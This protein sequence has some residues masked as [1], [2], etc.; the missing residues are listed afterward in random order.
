VGLL[1]ETNELQK[2]VVALTTAATAFCLDEYWLS[3]VEEILRAHGPLVVLLDSYSA[4]IRPL[5]LDENKS[6]AATPLMKLHNLVHQY[7][8]TLIVIHH[9]NKSGG[10]GN[11]AKASRG[12]SAI[13]AAADNLI[14]MRKFKSDDEEGV[15]KY[16]L[17]VEGRAEAEAAPLLGFSKHSNSWMSCGSVREH[18]EEQMKDD[19]Y[20][21]LTQPQLLVLDAL[22]KATVEEK[23]GLT[24][25]ELADAIHEE[26]SKSQQVMMS[27]TV[28]RLV[29]LGFA[30]PNPGSRQA[31]RYNQNFY[32][33]TGWAVAKHQITL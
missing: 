22:V 19:K 33:A 2:G 14:E 31:P 16:E 21:G 15:K 23:K 12:S 17:H 13:T 24:V 4:A 26:S 29:D 6:E 27:K 7:K 32:Q 30:Y 18:R 20:D 28:K 10:D 25:K 5:G 11:A 3:R 1:T 9:A 8:S